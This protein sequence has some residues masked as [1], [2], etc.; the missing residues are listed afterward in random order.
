[1]TALI[2]WLVDDDEF[3]LRALQRMLK[4]LCPQWEI[5]PF[6]QASLMLQALEHSPKPNLVICDRI[7]PDYSGEQVLTQVRYLAPEAVRALLTADTSADIVIEDLADIHHFLA[8]PFTE[9]DVALVFS[10]AEQLAKLPLSSQVRQELGLLSQLPI[11]PAIFH[12]LQRLLK[13]EQTTPQELAIL[14]AQ[15]AVLA[16]KIL[17]LANSPFMGFSRKTTSLEEAV[18]RLGFNLI[19]S[20]AVSIYCEQELHSQLDAALHQQISQQ[21]YLLA[22]CARQ[23]AQ[24][25]HFPLKIQDLA[26]MAALFS[27]LGQLALAAQGRDSQ[28]L[29]TEHQWQQPQTDAVLISVY[30]LTLWGFDPILSKILLQLP[31]LDLTTDEVLLTAQLLYLSQLFIAEQTPPAMPSALAGGWQLL[32]QVHL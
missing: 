26:F 4:R 5:R 17:Q 15:D 25:C 32:K 11:L 30:L 24:L 31:A 16:G 28:L 21:N 20:I 27:G 13:Q 19:E 10:C 14:L 1:M 23:L 12:Q 2:A 22:G 6:N 18:L 8:K 9:S 29:A 3:I 7:M